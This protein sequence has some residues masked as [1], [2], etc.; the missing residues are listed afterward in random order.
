MSYKHGDNQHQICTRL[1][2]IWANMLNRCSKPSATCYND[3]GG[4][5]IRVCDE[6]K[7]YILFRKW[8]LSSGYADNLT[9][10]RMN[11]DGNY[12][13]SNCRWATKLEQASNKRNNRNITFNGTT[14]TLTQWANEYNINKY[15]LLSRIDK[16]GWSIGK[17]FTT[18][19]KKQT[20]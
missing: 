17:A 13:P 11:N 1:Y 20:A 10:D 3:Y 9:I 5:G 7:N 16:L 6:W 18:P 14:Q 19:V 12:E 15:T 2:R 8:A 4:R